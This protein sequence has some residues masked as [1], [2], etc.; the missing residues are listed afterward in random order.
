ME[1]V[2]VVDDDPSVSYIIQRITGMESIGFNCVEQLL[3]SSS[4]FNPKVIFLD[5]LLEGGKIGADYIPVLRER[6]KFTPILAITAGQSPQLIKRALLNG[7]D[8]FLAKPF[9][10]DEF[11]IRMTARIRLRD[12]IKSNEIIEYSGHRLDLKS[13][14]LKFNT[15][16]VELTKQ[17]KLAVQIFFE[18]PETLVSKSSFLSAVWGSTK[19]SKKAL[20]KKVY[21][22]RKIFARIHSDLVISSKYGAGYFLS[23]KAPL[24]EVPFL[25]RVLVVGDSEIGCQVVGKILDNISIEYDSLQNGI[26]VLQQ[27]KNCKYELVIIQANSP[28]ISGFEVTEKLKKIYFN[29]IRIVGILNDK[30]SEDI[31]R[32]QV[33]GMDHVITKPLGQDALIAT[34]EKHFKLKQHLK[35]NSKTQELPFLPKELNEKRILELI[36]ISQGDAKSL[37]GRLFQLFETSGREITKNLVTSNDP[38][39]KH[40]LIQKLKSMALNIGADELTEKCDVYLEAIEDGVNLINQERIQKELEKVF[41]RIIVGCTKFHEM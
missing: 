30:N 1:Y 16:I 32:A 4:S 28:V 20:E 33:S 8:D 10:L 29:S 26:E 3:K 37:I 14:I 11:E 9:N 40:Y 15:G 36:N 2:A 39:E 17:Q 25:K 6:W 5:M 41:S 34:I 22:L 21:D 13:G 31:S 24:D 7:A 23:K 12:H 18:N 38:I 35:S 27:V 19:V